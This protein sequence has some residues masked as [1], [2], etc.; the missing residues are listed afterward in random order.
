MARISATIFNSNDAQTHV[1]RSSDTKS[2]EDCFEPTGHQIAK[3]NISTKFRNQIVEVVSFTKKKKNDRDRN[4]MK[5][6]S[7]F[8]S[9]C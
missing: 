8:D 5:L 4:K 3:K 1:N 6:S 7:I 9:M 2:I